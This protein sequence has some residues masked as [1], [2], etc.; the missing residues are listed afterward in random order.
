M[1]ALGVPLGATKR[2]HIAAN[3]LK[4]ETSRICTGGSGSHATPK[5]SRA[6]WMEE[7]WYHRHVE[8]GDGHMAIGRGLPAADR[9]ATPSWDAGTRV[10]QAAP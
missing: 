2:V 4:I 3:G 6:W 7:C 5:K 9:N 1:A 8:L 10:Q